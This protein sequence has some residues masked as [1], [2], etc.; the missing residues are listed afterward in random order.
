MSAPLQHLLAHPVVAILR[1]VTPDT[2]LGVAQV[3][4]DAGF[5]VIEVPLNSPSPLASIEALAREFGADVLV[6]AGT[7]LSPAQVDDV[8]AAG[9]GLVLSPNCHAPVIAQTLRHGVLAMPGVATPSEAFAALAAGAQTLKLFPADV[10]GTASFKGW[11]AVLPKDTP[12]F[13]VGGIDADNLASFRQAGAAGVGLGSSLYVPGIGLTELAL[14]ARQL[15]AAW[16]M[17]A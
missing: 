1:G 13:G 2:V 16:Q 8:V 7:V 17:A 15:L 4:L 9:A 10:L 5:R 14:R 3:L 12:M 11:R 6:G